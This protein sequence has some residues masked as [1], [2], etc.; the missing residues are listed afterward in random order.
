MKRTAFVAPILYLV[1]C[2]SPTDDG[3]APPPPPS[4]QEV[5]QVLASLPPWTTFSPQ[6]PDADPA[7]TSAGVS[8]E[9]RVEVDSV[10]T[11]TPE[12]FDIRENVL[13]ACD[14]TTYRTTRTPV[15][16]VMYSPP[17]D[18]LWPG[19]LIQGK[20][21]RDGGGNLLPLT[22]AERD[23]INV[24]IPSL[25]TGQNFRTVRTV[26]QASVAGAI[27]DMIGNAVAQN[28]NTG[29]TSFFRVESI[30]NE[31]Q[32]ALGVGLSG[33]YLGWRARTQADLS[34][35]A[36]Q[37]T[38]SVQFHQRMFEVVVAPPQT[39][40]GFFSPAFSK[41]KLDEQIA[42]GR[43]GADNL[44]IYVS[45]VT[46]GRTMMFTL[47]ASATSSELRGLV[48]ASYDALGQGAAASLSA[49]QKNILRQSEIEVFSIGGADSATAT[50]IKTGDWRGYFT[51]SAPLST[52]MPIAYEFKNLG[53][54]SVAR[55]SEV[56][57]FTTK[58]CTE[59]TR[60]PGELHFLAEQRIAAPVPSPY[61]TV[62]A[63][64]SGDGRDD[65]IWNH[66]TP[67]GNTVA[68]A[69]ADPTGRFGTPKVTVHP[70]PAATEGWA[71]YRLLTGDIT[72][73]N[74][75]DLLWSRINGTNTLYTAVSEGDGSFAYRPRQQ[76]GAANWGTGY[77]AHLGRFDSGATADLAFNTLAAGILNRT[78]IVL[79]SGDGAFGAPGT[80]LDY[81]G[82]LTGWGSYA[83]HL[84][85]LNR[86]GQDDFV[87]SS[88]PGAISPNRTY[89]GIRSATG[90]NYLPARDHSS[91]CCWNPYR[92]LL[93]DFDGDQIPDL[94][95]NK[96]S[97]VNY[98]HRFRGAGNGTWTQESGTDLGT[99]TLGFEPSL[100]DLNDDGAMDIVWARRAAGRL[101]IRVGLANR[102]IVSL[103]TAGQ[104]LTDPV[105]WLAA[106]LHV[107][108]VT[109][110]HRAD[111]VVVI[112]EATTR[113]FV[114]ATLP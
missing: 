40:A 36:S 43:I 47:K 100:G 73:D 86:D 53:D 75:A 25:A 105:N 19:A 46:Y 17:A 64:V 29:A 14:T 8:F 106:R 18:I 28:L 84:A 82:G 39:P 11:N 78:Y 108:L 6:K 113:V 21:H 42:L 2:S 37:S 79:S 51:A 58:T 20:S 62:L 48:Q 91:N 24:S 111:V 107:G 12:K 104:S 5:A 67:T 65:L 61:E 38:V 95:W 101:D 44:P 52:A 49:R 74:R 26:N 94:Y 89:V 109:Q 7:P 59:V 16:L 55:V 93:A 72:G 22:I 15:D 96:T 110:D 60:M 71:N 77:R 4:S 99:A 69:L 70:G 9:E 13:Y 81:P 45:R 87:W 66:L 33:R 56:T 76:F 102:G 103:A 54:G 32:F 23:S 98:L 63:D 97:D 57:D 90:I 92:V 83:L 85:D 50:M 1:A 68:V 27:G 41:A 31:Q 10:A 30:S 80:P 3:G 114:G 34:R 35:S 88:V 112:P